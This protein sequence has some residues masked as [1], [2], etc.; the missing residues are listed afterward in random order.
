VISLGIVVPPAF[1]PRTPVE[2]LRDEFHRMRA[3]PDDE[4]EIRLPLAVPVY[5][6]GSPPAGMFVIHSEERTP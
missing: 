5:G 4:R 6:H 1:R 2:T 3:R